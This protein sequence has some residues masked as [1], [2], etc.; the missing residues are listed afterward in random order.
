MNLFV[1]ED[2]PH[3][4]EIYNNKGLWYYCQKE[5]VVVGQEKRRCLIALDH[6][7]RCQADKT[8]RVLW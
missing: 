4:P 2:K 5:I 8:F 7:K 1:Y 6:H 3:K